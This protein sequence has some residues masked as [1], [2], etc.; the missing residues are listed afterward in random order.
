MGL[1]QT[2]CS[3]RDD[4]QPRN[5]IEVTDVAGRDDISKL[6]RTRSDQKIGKRQI[7]SLCGLLGADLSDDFGR[8]FSHRIYRNG[9]PQFVEKFLATGT[10]F[11]SIGPIYAVT[12]FGNGL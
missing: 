12:D 10:G 2:T 11:S 3:E 6:Q 8:E 5:A 1:G 9:G 7:D 4:V